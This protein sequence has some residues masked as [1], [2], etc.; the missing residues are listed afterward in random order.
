MSETWQGRYWRTEGFG[1]TLRISDAGVSGG[2]EGLIKV[3]QVVQIEAQ[4]PGTGNVN[5]DDL[6]KATVNVKQDLPVHLL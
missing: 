2:I 4:P 5:L 3:P 6:N 1:A